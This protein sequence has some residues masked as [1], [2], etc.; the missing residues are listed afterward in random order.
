LPVGWLLVVLLSMAKLPNVTIQLVQGYDRWWLPSLAGPFIVIELAEETPI[1]HIE[2]YRGGAFIWA[3]QEV[4]S[5]VAAAE[6]ITQKAMTPAR[7]AEVI[8][9]LAEMETA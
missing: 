9:E 7:T 8:A 5:Y 1:V 6:E 2:H 3:P 4:H